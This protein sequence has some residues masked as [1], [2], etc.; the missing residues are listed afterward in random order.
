[1]SNS[2]YTGIQVGFQSGVAQAVS[3]RESLRKRNNRRKR[4]AC[5]TWQTHLQTALVFLLI[6]FRQSA[7]LVVRFAVEL[8]HFLPKVRAI[9]ALGIAQRPRL[10]F[11][12]PIIW[13]EPLR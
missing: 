13:S 11:V 1:M 2:R 8:F 7:R 9:V 5:A 4:T 6:P 10:S 3:L 12:I